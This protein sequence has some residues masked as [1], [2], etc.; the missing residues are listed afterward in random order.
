MAKTKTKTGSKKKN[1]NERLKSLKESLEKERDRILQEMKE[2]HS[3]DEI[4]AHGDLVDQSNDYS[5]REVL[6]GLAEHD[7]NRLL[8]INEA[9]SKIEEGTYGVCAMCNEEIPEARLIAM[10]TAKY[11]IKCQSE[12][13]NYG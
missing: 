7:R 6:L 4:V 2:K 5:E 9:L 1:M 11:C 13:E 3:V 8:S 10:P 12:A